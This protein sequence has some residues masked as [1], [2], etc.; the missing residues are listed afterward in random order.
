MK[1]KERATRISP[2]TARR[3]ASIRGSGVLDDDALEDVG[4]VLA[5]IRRVFEKIQDLFP[6][7]NRNGIPLFFEE[8][9]DR[10]LMCAV[11][12]VLQTV[13]FYGALGDAAA[14]LE[15]LDGADDLVGGVEDDAREV[16]GVGA[17]L[18]NP[19]ERN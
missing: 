2:R 17:D 10:G 6:L 4:D 19:I 7:D 12:F 14:A 9:A 1:S 11:G 18:L 5:A 15:R 16:A 3:F 8:P 13:D